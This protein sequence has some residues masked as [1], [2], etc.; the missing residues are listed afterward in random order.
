M[1]QQVVVFLASHSSHWSKDQTNDQYCVVA[2]YQK[3]YESPQESSIIAFKEKVLYIL[4][5]TT[6]DALLIPLPIMFC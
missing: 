5:F 1:H 6:K 4:I 2:G 3:R